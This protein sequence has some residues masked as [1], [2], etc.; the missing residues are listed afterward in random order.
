[1][2]EKRRKNEVIFGVKNGRGRLAKRGFDWLAFGMFPKV[3]RVIAAF[4]ILLGLVGCSSYPEKPEGLPKEEPLFSVMITQSALTR[5][6]EGANG[7]AFY[8]K[9]DPYV[10]REPSD[11][12]PVLYVYHLREGEIDDFIGFSGLTS[13]EV[14]KAIEAIDFEPFDWKSEAAI[15]DARRTKALPDETRL[16]TFD[17][18][19]YEIIINSKQGRFLMREWNPWLEIEYYAPYSE[20]IAKLKRVIDTLA[21]YVGRSKLGFD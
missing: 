7:W 3:I 20:K 6:G 21:L 13:E 11:T 4:G 1:M 16:I 14:V 15:A 5:L 9:R 12:Y 17:G 10:T 19:E 8:V 2:R 18:A